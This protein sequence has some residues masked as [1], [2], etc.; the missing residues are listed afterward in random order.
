V[1]N[2]THALEIEASDRFG[3][4]T[5]YSESEEAIFL[6]TRDAVQTVAFEKA[7]G[8]GLAVCRREGEG[9][10][11]IPVRGE[12]A[13]RVPGDKVV[14]YDEAGRE[15]G[16]AEIIREQDG[17]VT[18]RPVANAFSYRIMKGKIHDVPEV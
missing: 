13:F 17:F 10:E 1:W 15:I 9:W 5:D 7:R 6:D 18:V 14:A 8:K 12:I 11:V 2:T 16:T 4:R 3:A